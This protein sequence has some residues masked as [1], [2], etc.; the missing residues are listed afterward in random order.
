MDLQ[1]S[2]GA[3]MGLH[4]RL[5]NMTIRQLGLGPK[6]KGAPAKLHKITEGE[7]DPETSSMVGGGVADYDGSGLRVNYK[8]YDYKEVTINHGDFKLYLCPVLVD[9]TDTP[10]PLIGDTITFEDDLY[11]VINREPWNAAGVVCGWKLQMRKG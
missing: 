2:V 7:F 11:K 10:E 9:G 3:N 6:G 1:K 4:D 8:N 5:R